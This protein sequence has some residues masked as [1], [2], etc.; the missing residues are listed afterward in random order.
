[1]H[2]REPSTDPS[3]DST[4][5]PFGVTVNFIGVTAGIW[6][7]D[8]LQNRNVSMTVASPKQTR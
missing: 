7:R 5:V 3:V 8:Y 6:V 2:S 4:K 1:M